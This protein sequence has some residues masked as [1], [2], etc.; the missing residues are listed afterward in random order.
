MTSQTP[1]PT[2]SLIW[3][4]FNRRCRAL[5]DPFGEQSFASVRAGKLAIKIT[6]FR[7]GD[8]LLVAAVYGG[9]GPLLLCNER[10]GIFNLGDIETIALPILRRHM[11]LDDLGA[12]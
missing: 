6:V 4:E 10:S 8:H 2:Q 7:N 3:K 9:D 5:V 1:D 11:V 12:V